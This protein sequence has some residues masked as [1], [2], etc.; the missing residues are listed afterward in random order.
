MSQNIAEGDLVMVVKPSSCCGNGT[1]LGL[2]FTVSTFDP[3]GV[4]CIHCGQTFS[5]PNVTSPN[6]YG[7]IPAR[8]KRIPPHSVSESSASRLELHAA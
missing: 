5:G 2:V 4:R 1:A 7:Y 3:R 8:L 6:G